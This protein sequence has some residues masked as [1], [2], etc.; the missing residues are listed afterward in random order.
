MPFVSFKQLNAP[1]KQAMQDQPTIDLPPTADQDYKVK[2]KRFGDLIKNIEVATQPQKPELVQTKMNR[3]GPTF[4]N[5]GA[6]KQKKGIDLNQHLKKKVLDDEYSKTGVLENIESLRKIGK[7][8]SKLNFED[9]M[10][11]TDNMKFAK[12]F[13]DLRKAYESG[14]KEKMQMNILGS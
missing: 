6:Y 12:N 8:L 10:K 7:P 3:M 1:K 11:V 13:I 2:S 4:E 14:D 9:V 5:I